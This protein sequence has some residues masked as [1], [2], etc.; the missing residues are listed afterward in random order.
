MKRFIEAVIVILLA[1]ALLSAG[2]PLWS[3][4]IIIVALGLSLYYIFK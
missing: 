3:N 4:I 1:A 2:L